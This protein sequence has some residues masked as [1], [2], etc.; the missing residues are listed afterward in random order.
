MRIVEY[1]DADP[2]Q[3]LQLTLLALDFP[4][5][6]EHAGQIRRTDPRPLPCLTVNAVEG[7]TVLG[8]VGVFRL[9]MVSTEGRE[10]VG[11]LWALA[12]HP[13]CRAAG[14]AQRL[15]EE[16]HSRMRAA[17]LRFS[18]FG[19]TRDGAAYALARRYGYEEMNVWATALARW[20][21]AHQPT[22]LHARP[23][24]PEDHQ[25]I[26]RIFSSIAGGYLGFA[27]R[28]TPFAGLLLVNPADIWILSKNRDN[29]GY[30]ITRADATVLRVSSLL[31]R[32]SLD[33]AEAIAAVAAQVKSAYVQVE[34]SRPVE[35]ASLRRAG[36]QVSSPTRSGFLVKPL[37]PD[38]T[39]DDARHLF[40]IG[41]DRFLISWL[42]VTGGGCTSLSSTER[43]A[44]RCWHRDGAAQLEGV[45]RRGGWLTGAVQEC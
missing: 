5:T 35:I 41:T 1:D 16:A 26:E 38:V 3:V 15:L 6:P 33:T 40:G 12:T 9:P 17:G 23:L 14:V 31:L 11:G 43:S 37:V 39:H 7:D 10:D 20:E 34:V 27:W 28:H 36:Y 8:Q 42:D 22:R 45:R 2:W 18:A 4:L 19:T 21:T 32:Q 25:L 30:A 29:V 24:L 44:G 13:R